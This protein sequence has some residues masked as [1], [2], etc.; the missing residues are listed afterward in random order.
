MIN[1]LTDAAARRD[2]TEWQTEHCRSKAFS[3]QYIKSLKIV[4][5]CLPLQEQ[6][7]TKSKLQEDFRL[8]TV[9]YQNP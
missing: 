2:E 7:D 1:V 5:R 8:E 9:D 6:N 4:N 3:N